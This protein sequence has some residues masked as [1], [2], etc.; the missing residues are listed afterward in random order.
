MTRAESRYFNTARRMDEALISLLEEKDFQYITIKELCARAGVNRSTFYLHYENMAD[1]LEESVQQL[2]QSFL[3]Y[4]RPQEQDVF[5]QIAAG[6]TEALLLMTPKYLTPYL[7]Y[8]RDHRR[9]YR[10]AMEHPTSFRTQ[11][12]YEAMFRTIFDPILERFHVPAEERG[13]MMSFFLGGISALVSQWLEKDCQ[14]SIPQL[15][16]VFEKCI[17]PT[18]KA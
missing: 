16:A 2:H 7:Q 5:S 6:P 3:D 8:V 11:R 17:H 18:E 15:L 9:L 13:Y 4:F 14:D 12:T 10:A 1:L